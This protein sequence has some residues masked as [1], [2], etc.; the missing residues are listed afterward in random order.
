M[1]KTAIN[2]VQNL[3]Q[4]WG[5]QRYSKQK[6]DQSCHQIWSQRYRSGMFVR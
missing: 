5:Y 6:A 2:T 4:K 1:G 3:K